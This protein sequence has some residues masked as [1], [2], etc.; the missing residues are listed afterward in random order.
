[1]KVV[2]IIIACALIFLLRSKYMKKI[3]EDEAKALATPGRANYIRDNFPSVVDYFISLDNAK[4][5]LERADMIKIG[6]GSEGD[7]YAIG[8]SSSGLH[9]AYVKWSS[10]QKEWSFKSNEDPKHI[11]YEVSKYRFD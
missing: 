11:I 6:I 1:M 2:L 8:N 5:L 7:Y 3:D 4:I 10:V 9:I